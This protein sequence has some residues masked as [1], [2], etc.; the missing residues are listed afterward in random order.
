MKFG[1]DVI[2]WPTSPHASVSQQ[3][4]DESVTTEGNDDVTN[5]PA[6]SSVSSPDLTAPSTNLPP[7]FLHE[8][9]SRDCCI[10]RTAG[11]E[12]IR[13]CTIHQL[14]L[15]SSA[16]SVPRRMPVGSCGGKRITL[17]DIQ[18]LSSKLCGYNDQ[19][20]LEQS[21]WDS[22]GKSFC[23]LLATEIITCKLI[24]FCTLH[25]FPTD[26]EV[27]AVRQYLSFWNL[28]VKDNIPS[29]GRTCSFNIWHSDWQR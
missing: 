29:A 5:D 14:Y 17:K 7:I 3:G 11:T 12:L 19:Q 26:V 22:V 18:N 16:L 2:F 24:G 20:S 6:S 8:G 1:V 15:A 9:R 13:G 25:R 27:S 21:L 28:E 10:S 4:N 23:D